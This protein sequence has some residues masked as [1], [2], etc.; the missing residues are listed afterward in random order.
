[1]TSRWWSQPFAPEGSAAAEGI[2]KQL[3]QPQLDPLTVLVREAA[4]NSW[5]A[6]TAGVPVDFHIRLETLGARAEQW[7]RL[8]LPGPADAAGVPLDDVLTPDTVVL[9]VSDRETRGLGG[10]L[11]AG[12]RPAEGQKADFV[13]FLRNVGEPNDNEFGGGTYGFGKGI[14]YRLS[15]VA[16]ILVDT[17]TMTGERRLMGAA[18]GNSWYSGDVRYTGRHWWADLGSDGIPDPYLQDEAVDLAEALG[19]PG[20]TD[21]RTGTDV[22]LIAAD[23]GTVDVE[24]VPRPRTTQEAADFLA[25]SMLWNLWPKTI[26]RDGTAPMVLDVVVDG[27]PIGVPDPATVPDLRPFVASLGN[28]RSG[29]TQLT[30]KRTVAPKIAGQLALTNDTAAAT[31]PVTDAVISS[32][33][34]FDGPSH[35]VAR[36]RIAELVVDYLPTSPHPDPLLRY[37][38]VFKSTEES[39]RYFASAEPPTHDDWVERGLSGTARGVVQ[40]ARNYVVKSVD[41]FL[42]LS[43]S[44]AGGQGK[45]LGALSSKLASLLPTVESTGAGLSG[46][47]SG[48]G[49]GRGSRRTSTAARIVDGPRLERFG[50]SLYLTAKVEVPQMS[51]PRRLGAE[52]SVVVEGGGRESEPPV[53]APVPKVTGWRSTDGRGSDGPILDLVANDTTEWWVYSSYVPDAVVRF[54]VKEGTVDAG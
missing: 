53:G 26:A 34:P 18:L 2:V 21:G 40:G 46:G 20:F 30:Y 52:V 41:S 7:R 23:L 1:M 9:T 22:V 37:A 14:F 48:G 6:G 15:R 49:S 36:M 28:V 32:A 35:H 19:L 47:G 17:H 51:V 31:S 27:R 10:P 13:Q 8:L 16:T 24:G 25:S 39:D 44:T 29:E 33:R 38:G 5:D 45:G 4:Q 42:G 54:R 11:R 43:S 3:G 12:A 50:D